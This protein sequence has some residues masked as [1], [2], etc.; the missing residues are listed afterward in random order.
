MKSLLKQPGI[1][2]A[3]WITIGILSHEL[4]N[5]YVFLAC[6]L[7]NGILLTIV[8]FRR[9]GLM[10][11][12]QNRVAAILIGMLIAVIVGFYA[13]LR[14][15]A[16]TSELQSYSN[17]RYIWEGN[18]ISEPKKTKNAWTAEVAIQQVANNDSSLNCNGKIII[19][20]KDS[21]FQHF[22]G[23]TQIR[24]EGTLQ[25]LTNTGTFASYNQFLRRN[26]FTHR[27]YASKVY[28]V[29]ENYSLQWL[30]LSGRRTCES[31][32]RNRI[33]DENAADVAVAMLLG[34]KNGLDKQTKQEYL[35]AGAAHI[36]AISGMHISLIFSFLIAILSR[37]PLAR[38]VQLTLAL[39]VIVGYGLL[40]GASP[41]VMRAVWTAILIIIAKFLSRPIQPQNLLGIVWSWMLLIDPITLEDLGFQ[42][43]F[44]AVFGIHL[45][46]PALQSLF[47]VKNRFLSRI[48]DNI[49]LSI[50]A[51]T[52]TLPIIL[53]HFGKF[54][55]WFLLT[56]LLAV[57]VSEICTY[58]G[59]LFLCV[60][61]VPGVGK[62]ISWVTEFCFSFLNEVIGQIAQLPYAT[63]D[64]L[65]INSFQATILGLGLLAMTWFISQ[66]AQQ[67][68]SKQ[69]M[70]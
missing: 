44:A 55:S 14:Q 60:S 22:H 67:L 11:P 5:A 62:L 45:L 18:L 17:H 69:L 20:T 48:K 53:L 34:N 70:I 50:A 1:W 10:N 66:K 24:F 63:L 58:A 54:P 43:S 28:K 39:L 46:Y 59:F 33:Q 61:W 23:G 27:V 38:K 15:S 8:G 36:L 40:T 49:S 68:Q 42:L 3:F 35:V 9:R 64:N 47:S 4:I 52:F 41:A 19:Y 32:I 30:L 12:M 21:C 7:L 31:A 26:G 57:P 51:Q 13:K 65:Q 2:I 37:L 16:T 29:R 25:E 56:N 6:L